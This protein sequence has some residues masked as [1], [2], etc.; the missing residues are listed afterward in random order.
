MAWLAAGIAPV[1]VGT[2]LGQPNVCAV[3]LHIEDLGEM[4]DGLLKVASLR[5]ELSR[6]PISYGSGFGLGQETS[7]GRREDQYQNGGCRRYPAMPAH[8]AAGTLQQRLPAPQGQGQVGRVSG[9]VL[10]MV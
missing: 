1:L 2:G 6:A 8:A 4:P 10:G 3:G 5:S 7:R 9:A